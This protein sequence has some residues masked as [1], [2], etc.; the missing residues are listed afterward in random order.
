MTIS[1]LPL[2]A[3][4][5]ILKDAHLFSGENLLHLFSIFDGIPKY[6]EELVDIGHNEFKENLNSSSPGGNFYGMKGR[7]C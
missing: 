6:I 1:Y 4:E 3:Q 7:I 5:E 2:I